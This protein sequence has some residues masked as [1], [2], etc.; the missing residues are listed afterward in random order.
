M[1]KNVEIEIVTPY[2]DIVL[3]RETVV[4]ERMKISKER[5]SQLMAVEK[6]K[7]IELF[8]VISIKKEDSNG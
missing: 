5:M 7:N 2:L 3:K 6:E 1:D 8:K 4:H